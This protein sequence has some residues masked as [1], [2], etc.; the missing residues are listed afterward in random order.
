M[1]PVYFLYIFYYYLFT[2]PNKCA[3]MRMW[4]AQPVP[5]AV[6]IPLESPICIPVP[7]S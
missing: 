1:E 4:T 7:G 5:P 6:Q 2:F 3:T